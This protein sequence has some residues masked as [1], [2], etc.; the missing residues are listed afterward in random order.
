MLRPNSKSSILLALVLVFSTMPD[1]VR[2]SVSTGN[3]LIDTKTPPSP[4]KTV[5]AG[6]PVSLCF[7]LVEF[8]GGVV[9]LYLSRNGYS[10]LD[11]NND[12]R[13]GPDFSVAE[14]RN[15]T[16]KN[17]DGYVVG[18]SWINGSIPK[19][20][21]GGQWFI[22][23]FDGLTASVAVT[24]RPVNVTCMLEVAPSSG[25]G[26]APIMLKGYG[27]T[28]NSHANLSYSTD[29]GISWNPLADLVQTNESGQFTYATVAPD[30][31]KVLPATGPIQN[32]TVSFRAQEAV[33]EDTVDF[34]QFWRGLAQVGDQKAASGML[35][36]NNTDFSASV[37]LTVYGD[38]YISGRYFRPG[39]VRILWDRSVH[40]GTATADA[41]GSFGITVK[42]PQAKKGVHDVVVDDGKI[43]FFFRVLV[44]PNLVLLPDKGPVGTHV[45]AY[46]SG[47]PGSSS[48]TA[49]N[50]TLWW[51]SIDYCS[52]Q[53]FLLSWV[54][55]SAQ[56]NFTVSFV[57]PH[58]YGETH[59]I[60]AAANDSTVA[61]ANFTITPTLRVDPSTCYNNGTIVTVYG[62][63]LDPSGKPYLWYID[64]A[65]F[66]GTYEGFNPDCRGNIT[67][68][69]IC[70]GFCCSGPH[71]VSAVKGGTQYPQTTGYKYEIEAY[72]TFVVVRAEEK[73]ILDEIGA[74][75][76]HVTAIKEEILVI[77]GEIVRIEGDLATIKTVLGNLT[78][79]IVAIEE[80]T[81]TIRTDLATVISGISAISNMPSIAQEAKVASE[82]AQQE[83]SQARFLAWV[84][85][86]ASVATLITVIFIV[87]LDLFVLPPD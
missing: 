79:R 36:G 76:A 73:A 2:V 55:A 49:Y 57:V 39:S 5:Q 21:A 75:N 41:E 51:D 67:F 78:G 32:S 62:N 61:Y 56:G 31:G 70:S 25:P 30:L 24:D 63:G 68:R 8:S 66:A 44:L 18:F 43:R 77:K 17:V 82:A 19:T 22:K 42:V 12:V 48:T 14:I 10:S 45:T 72:T 47:F 53:S 46:G 83:A 37:K 33:C 29:G 64:S 52:N 11:L 60:T 71:T 3:I 81:A 34:A 85:A 58:T 84:A 35:W 40:T 87:I 26:Q 65:L 59:T 1:I 20:I 74:L 28:A 13:Y 7:E 16:L 15:S 69:F 38:L 54:M 4:P 27:H 9:R 86:I 23:G 50:V 6:G 80:R